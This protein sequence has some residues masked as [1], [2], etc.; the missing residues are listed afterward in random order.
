ML[1]LLKI[2]NLKKTFPGGGGFSQAPLAVHSNHLTHGR[3]HS[4]E[5]LI[6][7]CYAYSTSTA[8]LCTHS[9]ALLPATHTYT[10]LNDESWGRERLGTTYWRKFF[11]PQILL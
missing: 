7:G 2:Q 11:A 9:L 5:A 4:L 10:A 1:H 8:K 3:Y 6:S